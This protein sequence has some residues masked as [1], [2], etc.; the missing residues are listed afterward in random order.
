MRLLL[1]TNVVVA[2]LL[3]NGAPRKLLDRAIDNESVELFSSPVLI[4]E[5]THT[6]D[7]AK[8]AK[9]VSRS[10]TSVPDLVTHY[11]ALMRLVSPTDTPRIVPADVDDDHVVAAALAANADLIVTGDG[12]LLGLGDYSGIAI[13]TPAEALRMVEAG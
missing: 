11:Q 2:G 3:W 5:L 12:H 1:D 7:Y 13:V 10:R 9:R 4:D 8:F 6:L